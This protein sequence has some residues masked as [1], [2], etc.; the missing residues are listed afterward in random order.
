LAAAAQLPSSPT[1]DNPQQPSSQQH[2]QQQQ[3]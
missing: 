2:Q 3:H 1:V